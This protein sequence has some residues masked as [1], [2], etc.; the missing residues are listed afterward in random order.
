MGMAELIAVLALRRKRDQISGTIAHYERLLRVT[1]LGRV[2][3]KGLKVFDLDRPIREVSITLLQK[4]SQ[5][6]GV[7]NVT[8]SSQG[9]DSP[10]YR[11]E[12]RSALRRI[13]LHR[14]RTHAGGPHF[15]IRASG[16][17]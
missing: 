10:G 13:D 16:R 14:R 6:R 4:I 9:Q 11:N 5:A 1:F 3:G 8:H 15:A 2:G 17:S 12:M 7:R